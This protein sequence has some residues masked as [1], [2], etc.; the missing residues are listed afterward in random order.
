[1]KQIL[2]TIITLFIVVGC[3]VSDLKL[4]S[5][6]SSNSSANKVNFDHNLFLNSSCIQCHENKRP[7]TTPLHGSGG[8]CITCHTPVLNLQGIRTWKNLS[9]YNHNPLPTQCI[10]C[11]ES[12][13]PVAPI[14]HAGDWGKTEDCATCHTF[15]TWTQAKFTHAGKTLNTCTECHLLTSDS[16]T[17]GALGS[18]HPNKFYSVLKN[19]YSDLET[20]SGHLAVTSQVPSPIP[21]LPAQTDFLNRLL[22]ETLIKQTDQMEC[23]LCH[24]NTDDNRKWYGTNQAAG[25]NDGRLTSMTFDYNIHK[26]RPSDTDPTSC[27]TC[28]EVLR[29]SNHTIAPIVLG[30]NKADCQACH[31]YSKNVLGNGTAKESDWKDLVVAFDHDVQKPITCIGCHANSIP[32]NTRPS[33]TNPN[34]THPVIAGTYYKIDCVKCHTYSTLNQRSWSNITLDYRTHLNTNGTGPNTCIQCH[35]IDNNSLPNTLVNPSHTKGAFLN[36]DCASCHTFKNP[37][38]TGAKWQQFV[39]PFSHIIINTSMERCDG[40]HKTTVPTLT[41]LA[42]LTTQNKIHVPLVAGIDCFT[43]HTK[44]DDWKSI[45]YNHTV[46]D[47]CN[48][49]HNISNPSSKILPSVTQLPTKHFPIGTTQCFICH[50]NTAFADWT[51]AT[52]DHKNINSQA[53][54]TCHNNTTYALTTKQLPAV[55]T[56][57]LS[58]PTG[59]ECN[60]CHISMTSFKGMSLPTLNVTYGHLNGDLNCNS[61]HTGSIGYGK[62]KTI[63]HMT[64]GNQCYTCHQ[65]VTSTSTLAINYGNFIIHSASATTNPAVL[66]AV[67]DTRCNTCH[68]GVSAPG[69]TTSAYPNHA[70]I[71]SLQCVSCHTASLTT[72]PKYSSFANGGFIHT[73]TNTNAFKT[74]N[75]CHAGTSPTGITVSTFIGHIPSTAEC[76]TCHAASMTTARNYNNFSSGLYTHATTDT[77]TTCHKNVAISSVT[78]VS[79]NAVHSANPT[80]ACNTCHSNTMNFTAWPVHTTTATISDT[81]CNICHTGTVGTYGKTTTAFSNH[82][83]IGTSQCISCHAASLKT[84]PKYLNFTSG[85]FIHDTTTTNCNSCHAGATPSGKTVT[86]FAGHIPYTSTVQC[87]SCHAASMTTARNYNNFTLGVYTHTTTDTCTTCHKNTAVTATQVSSTAVHS[88]NSSMACNTCHSNTVNFTA[89]PVHTTA[90]TTNDTACN[91]CHTGAVGTYGKTTTAFVNHIA[92]GTS[93]CISCHAASLKTTPKYLNFT[94]GTYH[95]STTSVLRPSTGTVSHKGEATCLNCHTTTVANSASNVIYSSSINAKTCAG[96]HMKAY[97][98]EH[99]SR[100]TFNTKVLSKADC[101]SCHANHGY[102]TRLLFMPKLPILPGG[103]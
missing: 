26:N 77:C 55:P 17:P 50:T 66:P 51:G 12:K 36:N 78:Q 93:Q 20:G 42:T 86:A 56:S 24:D 39:S 69:K 37:I 18:L 8:D 35:K 83:S 89:W 48:S 58:I 43:C 72:A 10:S 16:R 101:L 52:F 28:H 25:L 80:M 7:I 32:V 60:S 33:I 62:G 79:T 97:I 23:K 94:S 40:C 54:S 4:T 92:I 15:P 49:C 59:A 30:M 45:T 71:G 74:C 53:C 70:V 63:S 85:G 67:I 46:K 31:T 65:I 84:T 2:L 100:A 57:H 82:V 88:S 64:T 6:T 76:Y 95:H 27:S 19:I 41:N 14:A 47:T 91:S 81:A 13:R 61:C 90:T 34:P 99:D 102:E 68:A 38:T 1:M 11:H 29:P 96:C 44:T 98:G 3:K 75:T 5:P 103:I 87:S 22:N 9:F 73:A 21:L